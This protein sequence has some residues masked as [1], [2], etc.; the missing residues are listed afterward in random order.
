MIPRSWSLASLV[1]LAASPSLAHIELDSPTGRYNDGENKWCP[2][3]GG[4]DGSRDNAGCSLETSDPDRGS[5]ST[6][7]APGSTVTVRWRE[8]VGHTGRFRIS[9]DPDGADQDDFDDHIL[10]DIADPSGG[11]GNIGQGNVWE[12]DVTLPDTPCTNCTLQLVQ[13][14]NGNTADEVPSLY[15]TSTY[16]QCANLVLGDGSEGEGE[17]EGEGEP[18]EGEG[19]PGEGEGEG[20]PGEG[21]GDP[22]E[23]EG[24]PGEGEGEGEDDGCAAAPAAVPALLPALLLLAAQRRRAR[25]RG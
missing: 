14:M 19:E 20:E 15:G 6:T 21:E 10:A 17:G 16:F 7:F 3:G 12:L 8:T 1:A 4:G 13:V 23:G 9:F 25:A 2:C 5:T 24:E 11:N 18:G 22:G